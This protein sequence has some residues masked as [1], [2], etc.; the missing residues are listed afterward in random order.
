MRRDRAYPAKRSAPASRRSGA[1][2]RSDPLL[3]QWRANAARRGY[4]AVS[5][6]PLRT[7]DAIIG[8][9]TLVAADED[10]FDDTEARLLEELADDL[11]YGIGHLRMQ[12]RQ[13]EAEQTIERMAFQ[14]PLTGL[15]NRAAMRGTD[16][17]RPFRTR[18][19]AIARSPC[20]RS[21]SATSTRSATRWDTRP[22][23]G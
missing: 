2:S 16:R 11:G 21:T 8:C 5:A 3:T 17:D 22:A 13:L 9:L 19:S 14:D 1:G 20:C 6:F 15:P 10:A 23:T 4:G 7:G 18:A 12:N